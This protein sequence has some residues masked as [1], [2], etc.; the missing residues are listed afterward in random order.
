MCFSDEIK[1][2]SKKLRK[3]CMNKR[4]YGYVHACEE[5]TERRE[6]KRREHEWLRQS[7]REDVLY[8]ADSLDTSLKCCGDNAMG[9][10]LTA[11]ST[12]YT[13]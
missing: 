3:V 1:S 12:H 4:Y 9:I 2:I 8:S 13:Q 11:L 10:A 5:K 7:E 6:E